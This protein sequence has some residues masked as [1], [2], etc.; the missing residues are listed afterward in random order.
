MT[1]GNVWEGKD[2]KMYLEYCPKCGLENY[3]I[4]VASGQC[5]W[6]GY[7]ANKQPKESDDE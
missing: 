5:C 7:D 4:A 3:A 2:G 1:K 6:C